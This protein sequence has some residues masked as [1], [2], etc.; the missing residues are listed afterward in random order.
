ML[1]PREGSELVPHLRLYLPLFSFVQSHKKLS[2][3]RTN[4]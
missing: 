3:K 1:A 4:L 2:T